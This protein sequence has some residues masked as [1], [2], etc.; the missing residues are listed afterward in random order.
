MYCIFLLLMKK[1]GEEKNRKS[2]HCNS[3]SE[4]HSSFLYYVY[5]LSGK[6]YYYCLCF[7]PMLKMASKYSCFLVQFF[8][9]LELILPVTIA[10]KQNVKI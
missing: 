4:N 9:F 8:F 6:D 10:V 2:L 1:E 3:F 7:P 5:I